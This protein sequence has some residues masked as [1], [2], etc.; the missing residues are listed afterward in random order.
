MKSRASLGMVKFFMKLE[1][2]ETADMDV[3]STK[4]FIKFQVVITE[5]K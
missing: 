4:I 1:Q 2:T 5:I 3:K